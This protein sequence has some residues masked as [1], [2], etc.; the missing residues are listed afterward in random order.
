M[1][2]ALLVL[3]SPR[4][5]AAAWAAASSAD[6]ALDA[7]ARE[8]AQGESAVG[9]GLGARRED[10]LKWRHAITHVVFTLIPLWSDMP[11]RARKVACVR[12]GPPLEGRVELAGSR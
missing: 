2:Q 9:D 6:S 1:R 8:A 3:R 10:I 5:W 4:A 7:E 11:R 12:Q